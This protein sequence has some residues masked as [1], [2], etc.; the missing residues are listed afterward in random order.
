MAVNDALSSGYVLGYTESTFATDPNAEPATIS[1][2]TLLEPMGDSFAA[3]PEQAHQERQFQTDRQISLKDRKLTS[4]GSLSFNAEMLADETQLADGEGP[5]GGPYKAFV[6]ASWG[7]SITDANTSVAED[8]TGTGTSTAFDVTDAATAGLVQELLVS[9][10]SVTGHEVR[11]ITNVATNTL[12]VSRA[13]AGAP[14]IGDIVAPLQTWAP[15]R[16][17]FGHSTMTIKWRSAGKAPI[18]GAAVDYRGCAIM[19]GVDT[20]G[21]KQVPSLVFTGS[22]DQHQTR[23]AQDID[24]TTLRPTAAPPVMR[25]ARLFF[26]SAT[27]V[28][29]NTFSMDTGLGVTEREATS[30]DNGR[31]GFYHFAGPPTATFTT[32]YDDTLFTAWDAITLR[33]LELEI[34]ENAAG[35]VASTDYGYWFVRMPATQITS[36]QKVSVNGALYL[37]VQVKSV[38]SET[39]NELDF[40]PLYIGCAGKV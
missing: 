4:G 6:D 21:A 20:L 3:Q 23:T 33:Y 16:D 17:P 19:A 8:A 28:E 30:G 18:D 5:S 11:Q 38:Q 12:T 32:P 10:R 35:D 27:A 24:I 9:V 29:I 1:G 13:L 2:A 40:Y 14:G 7:Q 25:G 34:G 37:E 26:G 36:L 15:H 39:A 22:A 31:S